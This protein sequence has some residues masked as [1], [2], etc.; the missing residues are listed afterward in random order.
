MPALTCT[1][2]EHDGW[3]EDDRQPAASPG[4]TAAER[5]RLVHSCACFFGSMW[6]DWWRVVHVLWERLGLRSKIEH[7]GPQRNGELQPDGFGR[8]ASIQPLY[9]ID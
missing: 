6:L 2:E 3:K 7:D 8:H 1:A 9:L 4:T 5:Q